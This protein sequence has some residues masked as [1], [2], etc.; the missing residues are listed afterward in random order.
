MHK[1]NQAG[2]ERK[3]VELESKLSYLQVNITSYEKEFDG[4]EH[5]IFF[6]AN[7]ES[8]NAHSYAF[9]VL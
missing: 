9:L 7:T 2:E 5:E 1:V 6:T 8:H 3:E 4:V